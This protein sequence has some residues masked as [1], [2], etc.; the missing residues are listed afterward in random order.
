VSRLTFVTDE[1][2]P[3]ALV[4]ALKSEGYEVG[5]VQERFG[6]GTKDPEILRLCGEAGDTLLTND[7]DFVEHA[8]G[9]QHSGVVIY[10]E[11]KMT[12]R[13]ILRGVRRVDR[14]FDREEMENDVEWLEGW[15]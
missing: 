6:Q 15:L 12:V 8:A 9:I 2:V 13:H 11:Q 1:H 14:F 10:A 7:T 5:T 4:T 3:R